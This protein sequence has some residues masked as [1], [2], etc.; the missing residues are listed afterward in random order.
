LSS[1]KFHTAQISRCL[2]RRFGHDLVAVLRQL[3]GGSDGDV[4]GINVGVV[5]LNLADGSV[6]GLGQVVVKITLLDLVGGNN[7]AATLADRNVDNLTGE[8]EIGVGDLRVGLLKSCE[9]DFE[10]FGDLA[11]EVATADG[12]FGWDALDTG[13]VSCGCSYGLA[14]GVVGGGAEGRDLEDLAG[15]DEVDVADA[16]DFGNV[17][18]AGLEVRV[19]GNSGQSVTRLDGVVDVRSSTTRWGGGVAKSASYDDLSV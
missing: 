6:I 10:V 19:G 3:D 1:S 4:E 8:D 12:V 13:V 15:D 7:A 17:A 9:S 11:Q 5:S 14:A 18:D 2:P 16:V